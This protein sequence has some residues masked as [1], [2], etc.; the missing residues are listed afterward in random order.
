M[1]VSPGGRTLVGDGPHTARKARRWANPM[2]PSPY[3]TPESRP[4]LSA[5]GFM[6]RGP[7]G[8]VLALLVVVGGGALVQRALTDTG[9]DVPTPGPASPPRSSDGEPVEAVRSIPS[10]D[11]WV[12]SDVVGALVVVGGDTKGTTPVWVQGVTPGLV[13]VVV[14]SR[15]VE[16]DT[17]VYLGDGD[18]VDVSVR[19]GLPPERP[20]PPVP[21]PPAEE[22]GPEPLA[23]TPP[24]EAVPPSPP[25]SREPETM[26]QTRPRPARSRPTREPGLLRV[27]APPGT[28]LYV[29]GEFKTRVGRGTVDLR[30]TPGYHRVRAIYPSLVL[31][32][33]TVYVGR[34]IVV[35]LSFGPDPGG[36]APTQE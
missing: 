35:S 29:N 26:F 14:S 7:L 4:L 3:P 22:P 25:G 19:L 30:P 8:V 13:R 28:A 9:A 20:A 12:D 36:P 34:T 17:L 16:R 2:A 11:L 23:A 21:S 6:L 33:T 15:G 1:G 31:E 32:E 18:D 5:V 10:A 27:T 24:T